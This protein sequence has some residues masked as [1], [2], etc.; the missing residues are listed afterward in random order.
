MNQEF[1]IVLDNNE[2]DYCIMGTGLT[3]S[4]FSANLAKVGQ[5]KLL[6][7]DQDDT[8]SSGLRTLNFKEFHTYQS[9]LK[10]GSTSINKCTTSNTNE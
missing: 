1:D 4:L 7:I 9:R 8:Y 2:F 3:E 10:P 6:V 5:K